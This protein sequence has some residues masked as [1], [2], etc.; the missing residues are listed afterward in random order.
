MNTSF[1]CSSLRTTFVKFKYENFVL[2]VYTSHDDSCGSNTKPT[3]ISLEY[4]EIG[5]QKY[6]RY[7]CYVEYLFSNIWHTYTTTFIVYI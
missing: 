6:W 5:L 1:L 4:N 3:Q 2:F 7:F